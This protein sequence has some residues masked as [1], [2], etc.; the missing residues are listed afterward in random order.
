MTSS[1]IPGLKRLPYELIAYIV[2]G[3]DIEDVLHLSLCSKH[4]EYIIREDRFC[5]PVVTTKVPG[6]LEA[7][8]ALE[9]GGFSRALRRVAKRRSALSQASPYFMGIV[10]CAD[11]YGFFGG[12]L[13]Y[14]IEARPQRWLR[15][16][17]THKSTS[18][19][20]VVN[21]PMLIHAAIP[22]AATCRK[23][24]FKV[25]YQAAG[26]V[27]CL[28]SFATPDTENWL[29][30]IKPQTHQLLSKSR[31][32]SIARIFVRN[33]DKFLYYGTHSW[34]GADGLRK[35]VLK[36][37]DLNTLSWLT[38][39]RMYLANL[40][41]SDIGST[42]CFE[43]FGD[44]FYGLS[45]QSLFEAD[46]P[47]WASHYYCF[48]FPLNEPR[49]DKFQIMAKEDSWRRNHSEGPIDDRWGFLSLEIDETS[50]NTV[51]L[52]CRKEWLRNQRGSQRTYYT[53]DVVFRQGATEDQETVR[54]GTR[55]RVGDFPQ[56]NPQVPNRRPD[57]VHAGDDSSVES[58]LVRSKT[59]FCTYIR[60][61]QTFIDLID[62][63]VTGTSGPQQ[64]RLRTGYR[65]LKQGIQ[66]GPG[67]LASDALLAPSEPL[68]LLAEQP[69]QTNKIFIWPPAQGPLE[70]EPILDRACRLLNVHHDQSCVT[71]SGD[72]RSLIYATSDGSKGG[73]KALVLLSF[74]PAVR[75]EG[76]EYGGNIPGQQISQDHDE[77]APDATERSCSTATSYSSPPNVPLGAVKMTSCSKLDRSISMSSI[78]AAASKYYSPPPLPRP[79]GGEDAWASY[80]PAMHLEIRR[81]LYFG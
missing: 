61:C 49:L 2:E 16:L 64:L 54:V 45:N 13:C 55:R 12:K 71:A 18:W 60:C 22:R 5:K 21:I 81:K 74:D 72:E 69:Y 7:Q 77:E 36:G 58:L 51:I 39:P 35:W 70:T 65:R 10:A 52:E 59:H 32:D 20:L 31:L 56:W 3:L 62:E 80:S 19:E 42:V 67:E 79:P 17:D 15:I 4:F 6:T 8:Q 63:T 43:I 1:A 34:E 27:S 41:G 66:L 73:V 29:L 28:F 14:I 46:D 9:T 68:Q 11:S 48:R 47:E 40:A 44:Y 50:G 38:Q 23:Y 33:N 78:D 76:M 30:I 24:K 37:F 53:T 26:I 25:L 75:F 57:Y